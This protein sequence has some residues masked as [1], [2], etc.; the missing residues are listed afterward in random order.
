MVEET[1]G[2]QDLIAEHF[3][4]IDKALVGRMMRLARS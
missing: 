2:G 4:P 1:V 3:T